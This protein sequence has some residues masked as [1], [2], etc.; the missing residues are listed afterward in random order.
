MGTG[1]PPEAAQKPGGWTAEFWAPGH[2]PGMLVLPAA[3]AQSI[4]ASA[5]F[6]AGKDCCNLGLEA[7]LC[8]DTGMTGCRV[9][10]TGHAWIFG[11]DRDGSVLLQSVWNTRA[12]SQAYHLVLLLQR[13][14]SGRPNVLGFRSFKTEQDCTHD[15][16]LSAA[17]QDATS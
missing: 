3:A 14:W 15:I 17:L 10:S 11:Q 9:V 6:E 1:P 13:A 5:K 12:N 4:S 16:F 7:I 2:L 8:A